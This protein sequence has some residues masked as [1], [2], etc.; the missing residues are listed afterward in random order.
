MTIRKYFAT[1]LVAV[2]MLGAENGAALQVDCSRVEETAA[3]RSG[4]V[5]PHGAVADEQVGADC[6]RQATGTL[7]FLLVI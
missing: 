4:D 5:V 7:T 2:L 1:M 3:L 6:V